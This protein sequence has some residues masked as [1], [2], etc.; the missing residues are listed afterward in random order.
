MKP[1]D[2][3]KKLVKAML[4]G[5][6]GTKKTR[7]AAS[8]VFVEEMGPV[9]IL[10]QAANPLSIRDYDPA[11]Y[12]VTIENMKD[13]NEPYDWLI[14]GQP[15]QHVF[16][17]W[18]KQNNLWCDEPFRTVIIDG[19][20]QVQTF[21]IRAIKP[22]IDAKPGDVPPFTEL[23]DFNALLSMMT[24]WA[25]KY[26]MLPDMHVILTALEYEKQDKAGNIYRRP[27]LW[28][29]G[30]SMISSYAYIVMRLTS[31]EYMDTR[32]K[33]AVA[34]DLEKVKQSRTVGF[35]KQTAS[36]YAKEQYGMLDE[37]GEE[38]NYMFDPTMQKIWDAIG[39]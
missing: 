6:P 3:S 34:T 37:N 36:F 15:E 25:Y 7:T 32:T 16:A 11:P 8:A 12:I 21:A 30:E 31:S 14:K 38:M 35:L 1:A 18:L 28:G 24:N 4:Y 5:A 33:S 20:S 22:G 29:Q 23:R 26:M 17:T 19:I 13:Y 27:L 39:G 2:K 10:E 9:L